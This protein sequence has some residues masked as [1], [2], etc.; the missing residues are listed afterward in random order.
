MITRVLVM[1]LWSCVVTFSKVLARKTGSAR[2]ERV[3]QGT[4]GGH[5]QGVLTAW[6]C[7]SSVLEGLWLAL[8]DVSLLMCTIAL[9]ENIPS[10]CKSSIFYRWRLFVGWMGS[11]WPRVLL[12]SK[13]LLMV[14]CEYSNEPRQDSCKA[15]VLRMETKCNAGSMVSLGPIGIKW[16]LK[17]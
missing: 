16:P 5:I 3:G 10:L 8:G 13:Y 11:R 1:Q 15:L 2:A 9:I 14:V 7:L 4:M 6:L 17:R 12:T